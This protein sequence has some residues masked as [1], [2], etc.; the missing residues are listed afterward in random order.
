MKLRIASPL[1]WVSRDARLIIGAK[2]IRSFGQS[3]VAIIIA[4]YMAELNFSVFQ[5]GL[6]ITV[7]VIGVSFF[8]FLVGLFAAKIGRRRLLVTFS[9]MSAGA[10]VAFFFIDDFRLLLA[11]AFVGALVS[12][13]GG[14]GESAAQPLEMAS[15]AGT[16]PEGRRTDLFAVYSIGARSGAFFG[17]LAATFPE[18]V[19]QDILGWST[20]PSLRIMFLAFAGCQ[21]TGATLYSLLS[22]AI[23]GSATRHRWTNPLKLPSRR[24]I[25]TLTGLFSL[26]TFST[27]MVVQSLMAYWFLTNF[28]LELTSLAFVFAS[29]YVITATSLWVAAKLGNRIGLLN[30]MVF[31]HIP[32]NLFL[33]GAAFAPTAW[34]A[35]VFWQFRAL[36]TQ[37][38]VP[39]KDSYNMA[40]VGPDERVAFAS[41][42]QVGRSAAGAAAPI[43]TTSLWNIANAATPLVVSAIL[44]IT[45]DVS[46]YIMFRNVRPPEEE[47]RL[48]RRRD[49]RR[50]SVSEEIS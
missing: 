3:I 43:V 44:S 8:S 47:E 24:R 42:N 25:F 45:Y 20:L 32:S 39:T 33:I 21:L 49:A 22:P 50:T 2:G 17:A 27:S 37:M 5:L 7:G 18:V 6:F 34:I 16:A 29:S 36:L 30:T 46:L 13:G 14:G 10:A 23:E 28:G 48:R 38:D 26:D 9:M 19:F 35:I 11:V 1:S 41:I 31:T 12:G 15:L 4:S 40:I